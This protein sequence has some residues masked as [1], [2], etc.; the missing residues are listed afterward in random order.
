[1]IKNLYLDL[2]PKFVELN[3]TFNNKL[4]CP[5]LLKVPD[6]YT[7]SS[8]KV[9]IMGEDNYS[10]GC[11]FDKRNLSVEKLMC[12]YDK[13]VNKEWGDDSLF[14]QFYSAIRENTQ[15]NDVSVIAN[16][17]IKIGVEGKG[18]D[19]DVYTSSI[20]DFNILK[21]E[22]DVLKPDIVI[23]TSINKRYNHI[24]EDILGQY[25]R[26]KFDNDNVIYK[27][28]FMNRYDFE[29]YQICGP[30]YLLCRKMWNN[31]VNVLTNRI[32]EYGKDKRK[33]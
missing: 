19:K 3:K 5:Y 8:V 9:M 13:F 32:K 29:F 20:K 23:F 6:S 14:W 30:R 22:L 28:E 18:Y 7:K 10:W 2:L 25:N 31:V 11:E 21:D 26:F 27:Y 24:I 1:M 4:T 12:L 15:Y 33:L 17:I 16:N